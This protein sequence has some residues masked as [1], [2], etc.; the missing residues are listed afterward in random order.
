VSLEDFINDDQPQEQVVSLPNVDDND[1]DDNME[2][3]VK[4]W[5][6]D[7]CSEVF[8][9]YKMACIHEAKC[10][11]GGGNDGEKDDIV[12]AEVRGYADEGEARGDAVKRQR[13]DGDGR[14][15][16]GNGWSWVKPDH[17]DLEWL[18]AA[19]GGSRVDWSDI[20]RQ[21][22]PAR[23]AAACKGMNS[24]SK[25]KNLPA[26]TEPRKSKNR[27]LVILLLIIHHLDEERDLKSG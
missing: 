2:Y 20:G 1:D 25:R 19:A 14:K 21:M 17:D 26:I 8:D 9:S 27:S 6:C 24:G 13:E 18:I 7:V 5:R 3:M 15:H 22:S 23:T 12:C 11:L 4:A 10:V 16:N